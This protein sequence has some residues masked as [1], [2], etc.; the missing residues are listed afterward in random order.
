[1]EKKY[2]LQDGGLITAS[3]PEEF[4]KNMRLSSRF[5]SECTDQQYMENF[6]CRNQCQNGV[7][8]RTDNV[9][10]FVSDLIDTGYIESV[11]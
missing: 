10:H 6:S 3:G 7:L 2:R 9:E 4:V 5:D 1:M 11:S 8:V